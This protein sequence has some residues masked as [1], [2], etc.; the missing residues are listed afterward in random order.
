MKKLVLFDIDHTLLN[1]S[2]V[3]IQA[4][5]EAFKVVYGVDTHIYVIEPHGMTDQQ[6]IIDVLKKNGLDEEKI[7][8]KLEDAM[9]IMVSY[10]VEHKDE[11]KTMRPLDGVPELLEKLEESDHVMG[12][13]TGNLEPIA[14][15]KMKMFGFNHYFKVGGFGNDDANRTKLVE[16]AIDRANSLTNSEFGN[17][18]FVIGDSPKDIEAAHGAGVRVIG[19]TTGSYSKADLERAGADFIL[20]DLKKSQKFL[21]FLK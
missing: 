10:F 18:V 3:H 2:E 21:E 7:R 15:E 8:A 12:L 1:S 19:V 6:I 14:R 5:S 13:I 16:I 11:D 9:T 4:F 17:N 20:E